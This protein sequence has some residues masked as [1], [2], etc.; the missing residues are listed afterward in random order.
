[1]ETKP[2]AQHEQRY[3]DFK[4]RCQWKQ[5]GT[6]ILEVHLPGFRRQDIRIQ[7]NTKLGTLTISGEQPR[8]EETKSVALPR[9]FLKEIKISKNFDTDRIRAKFSGE[10]LSITIPKEAQHSAWSS[11][12]DYLVC[13]RSKVSRPGLSK[14][15]AVTAVVIV[16]V[17]ALGVCAVSRFPMSTWS[18]MP[19]IKFPECLCGNTSKYR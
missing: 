12:S 3:A 19:L 7:N 14:K 8:V 16:L 2:A 11:V 10:I 17:V 6:K 9:R 15:T 1:M 13:L 18:L 4:P 5:E